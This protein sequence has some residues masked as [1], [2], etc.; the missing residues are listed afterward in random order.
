MLLCIFE[1]II[2]GSFVRS[3]Q[4]DPTDIQSELRDCIDL[5]VLKKKLN[6]FYPQLTK[7]IFKSTPLE[8]FLT[9]YVF[10]ESAGQPLMIFSEQ[11]TFS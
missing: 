4:D 10:V 2:I 1:F 3:R 7:F 8:I 11:I 9:G 5:G 6:R